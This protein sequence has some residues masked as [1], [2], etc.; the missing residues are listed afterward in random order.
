VVAAAAVPAWRAARRPIAPLLRGGDLSGRE[1]QRASHGGLAATG[2]RFAVAARARWAGSVVTLGVCAGV[3][4]LMLALASLLVALRDDPAILGKRYQL[5]VDA[6]SSLVPSIEAVPG[7][8][9][10]TERLQLD[11]ADAFRL[12][13]PLRLIAY[14]GDHTRF[15]APALSAGRRIRRAGEVEVGAGLADALGLRPGSRLATLSPAGREL[16]LK[17]VGIV[18]A[19][20]NNGRIGWVSAPTLERAQPGLDGQV[21]I[22]LAP[23]ADRARVTA[24][25]RRLAVEPVSVGGA[26]T[27]DTSFLGILAGVLRAVALAVGL[28]CLYALLQGL[29][30]TARERRGALSV[31][32]AC[33]ASRADVAAVLGGAAAAVALPAAVLAVVLELTVFGPLVTRLA[34]GYAGLPLSP[35]TAQILAVAGGLALLAVAAAAAVARRIAREPVVAG[36]REELP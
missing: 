7:V 8:A 23:G 9:A 26:T 18:R 36:L 34:A 20:D 19:L 17:V 30:M 16:R 14:R 24:G 29:A 27:R 25:L 10:A 15:D 5:T 21:A 12:G 6:P 4:L 31:L 1:P 35:T 13:E 32:R 22:R 11:A 28:V 2:A 3:V 33:G